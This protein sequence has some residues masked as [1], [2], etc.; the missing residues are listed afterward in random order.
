MYLGAEEY[1]FQTEHKTTT[2]E[3]ITHVQQMKECVDNNKTDSI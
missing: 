1:G 2:K 3:A